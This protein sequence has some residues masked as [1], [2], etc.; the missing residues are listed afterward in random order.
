[1]L[2]IRRTAAAPNPASKHGRLRG[3]GGIHRL[4]QRRLLP[5]RLLQR[6]L[7]V[8]GGQ[9]RLI[10]LLPRHVSIACH[11]SLSEWASPSKPYSC[12]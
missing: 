11:A 5:A 2:P 3:G 9:F 10:E 6:P 1:M 7:R 8:A 12:N 4:L